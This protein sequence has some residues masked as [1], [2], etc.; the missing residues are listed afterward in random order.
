M[1]HIQNQFLK[2]G[3]KEKGAELASIQSIYTGQEYLWTADPAYWGR[4]SS[5]LFPIIGEV[6]GGY[7]RINGMDYP[8]GRH[9]FARNS[10]FKLIHKTTTELLFSLKWNEESIKAY[11][12]RFEFLTKYVLEDRKVSIHY[13]AKNLDTQP[14]LFSIGAHP[15]FNCPLGNNEKRSDY[16][17]VFNQLET[18]YS[19]LLSKE[20]LR[21]AAKKLVLDNTDT[22]VLKD[23]L[24]DEDALIFQGLQSNQVS[25]VNLKSNR[26]ILNFD[27]SGFPYLGIWSPNRESPF[28]CIEPWFGVA[29]QEGP[30]TEFIDKEGVISI[31]VGEEFECVHRVE[32]L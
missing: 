32:I 7:I 29:D 30:K 2:I 13:C 25:L 5:I 9:G 14:L 19:Q 15:G 16:A 11:P 20:G 26:K 17:L 3:I 10:T 23:D 1:V 27:F 6:S 12:F 8:L 21:L 18:A 31:N 4:H 28:V 22:L 24:F